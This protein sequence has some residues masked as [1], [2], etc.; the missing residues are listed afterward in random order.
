MKSQRCVLAA[1]AVALLSLVA[2][3]AATAAGPP[4]RDETTIL[5]KFKKPTANTPFASSLG[6]LK[7]K[8]KIVK[9][10]RGMPVDRLLSIYRSLPTVTYAEPNY[11]ARY[12]LAAPADPYTAELL[13][14]PEPSQNGAENQEVRS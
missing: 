13:R 7:T 10:K 8:V 12:H 5:V 11:I 2:T 4:P 9:A 6:E 1:A 3:G 14:Q